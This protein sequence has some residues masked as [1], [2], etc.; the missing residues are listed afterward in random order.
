MYET[1]RLGPSVPG[2]LHGLVPG[3]DGAGSLY[4]AVG[5]LGATVMPHVIYLHSAM[6]KDGCAQP[7]RPRMPA[8][9]S[10]SSGWTC[11]SALGLAGLVNMA[12][13]AVAARRV[14][15]HGAGR[16][17][18]HRPCARRNSAAWSGGGAALVF[19][20]A[21]LAS[22]VSS[23]S[24]GTYAG[25][26]IMAGFVRLRIPLLARRAITMLPS[27]AILAVG[28]NPT[29]ALVLSQVVLSFG[30]LAGPRTA[31]DSDQ[32]RAA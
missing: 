14:P 2:S 7:R 23:S 10:G 13:L 19:A 21:L 32:P 12:M 24:V 1:L 6:T 17:E 16:A 18:H 27:L 26:V 25:E 11:V 8:V 4:L 15:H 31:G 9:C 30:V 3:L 22:G 29:S 28:V 5:I 20:T